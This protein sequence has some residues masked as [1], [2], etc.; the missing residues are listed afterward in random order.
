M[1]R[2]SDSA[3][4]AALAADLKAM[5]KTLESRPVPGSIRSVADQLDEG[6]PD[7]APA[8]KGRGRG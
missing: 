5:F 4:K 2:K 7:G 8:K 1:A 3:K 6:E